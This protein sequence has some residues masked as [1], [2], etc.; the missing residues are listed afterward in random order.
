MSLEE[1]LQDLANS[2][3]EGLGRLLIR[4]FLFVCLVLAIFGLYAFFRFRGLTEPAAMDNAQLARNLAAGRGFVTQ[5]VRPSDLACLARVA[6]TNFPAL[7]CPDVRHA[8]LFP[9]LLAAGF[10]VLRPPAALPPYPGLF[11]PEARVIVPLGVLLAIGTGGLIFLTGRRLFDA[12]T[13]GLAMIIYFVSDAVLADAISGTPLPLMAFLATAATYAAV[14]GVLRKAEERPW[15]SWLAPFLLSAVLSGL[16]FLAG[17]AMVA[18]AV[19]LAGLAVV[20]FERWRWTGALV[21]LAIFAA[22]ASPWLLRNKRV[23]GAWLGAAPRAAVSQSWLYPDDALD[24]TLRPN[25][26]AARVMPAARAKLRTNL[27][28]LSDEN[29]R[30]LGGGLMLCFFL[31]SLFARF[32]RDEANRIRWPLLLGLALLFG[33]A[34]LAGGDAAG[35]PRVFLPFVVL[36]GTAFLFVVMEKTCF[37]EAAA[38][39]VLPWIAAALCALPAA[40]KVAAAP[41]PPPYPPYFPPFIAYASRLMAPDEVMCTDIPWAT[42]WYG[43]RA[44]LLLPQTRGEFLEIVARLPRLNALYL[45]QRTAN[46]PYVGALVSG[47]DRSWLPLLDRRL[48]PDFPLTQGIDFPP[49]TRDQ[50]LLFDRVRWQEAPPA[51]LAEDSG[52]ELRPAQ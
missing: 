8:P 6:G 28:R 52:L 43:N 22:V 16:A 12:R 27:L 32:E 23:S 15:L 21:F 29:L 40:I 33:L 1:K 10:K 5:C 51:G 35:L 20:G 34:A 46:R 47:A 45:T 18:L 49:G 44:S 50:L 41:A 31:A 37:L 4:A 9:A 3:E 13:G 42:A 48:P 25:L 7:P 24:R 38:P 26:S 17:Y 36:Y 14:V 39:A 11:P 2:L 19:A 30:P